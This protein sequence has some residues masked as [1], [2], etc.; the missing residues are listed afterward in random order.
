MTV[1]GNQ[2]LLPLFIRKNSRPLSMQENDELTLAFYLLSKNLEKNSRV[3]SFSGLLWPI[4]SIQGVISTHIMLDGLNLLK[5]LGRFSNPPRQPLIGHILRNIDNRTQVE[6]LDLLSD[7]LTYKDKEAEEIGEGEE[8]EFHTLKIDGLINPD[9]LQT[10]LSII[11]L[12][13]YKPI[14]DYTVLDVSISTENALSLSEEYR[15]IINTMKGNAYRW[16]TQIEL[17]EKEVSKWLIDLNVQLKDIDTRYSSQISKATISIDT[18]QVD[19]QTKLEQD[20]ID[21]W[22]VNEKKRIIENIST[23]FKTFEREL[24]EIIKKNRFFTSD[25]SLKSKVFEDLIPHF[26]NQFNY[27]TTE[28]QRFSE[29]LTTLKQK[30]YELTARASQIDDEA[31]QK[32]QQFKDSL[33]I[34]LKDRDKQLSEFQSEKQVKLSELQNLKTQIETRFETIKQIIQR[35]QNICLQEAQALTRWS[36][37]DNQSDLFSRP[38]QWIYMPVYAMFIENEDNMEEYMNILFP[39]FITTDPNNIYEDISATF[40]SLKNMLKNKMENDMAI[41]SNFEFSCER[42]NLRKDPNIIKRL[43]LGISVLREKGLLNEDS[44]N[45]IRENLNLIK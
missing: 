43:Q 25:D 13:E 8:S 40:V 29:T 18:H 35:K 30:F 32:L 31:T 42:K 44:E 39:G 15:Q 1:H 37:N 4:L 5:N 10:L 17:I 20:K 36:L 3:I 19:E 21:Q 45:L 16:K 9:F 41:R 23:F 27:L 26:E 11:P 6:Q 38:I 24:E 22:N 33:Q 7:V 2:Y 14:S 12:I 28:C 34:K